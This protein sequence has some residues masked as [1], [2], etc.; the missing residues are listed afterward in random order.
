MLKK[1]KNLLSLLLLG[2]SLSSF[3]D[4]VMITGN[5]VVMDQNGNV[6]SLPANYTSTTTYHYVTIGGTNRVC[7][8]DKQPDLGNLDMITINVASEGKT[9]AWDC[10]AYDASVFEITQ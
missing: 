3:A 4:K 5:P 8:L 7:Y 2:I 6:Y 9:V 1:I 10:Y